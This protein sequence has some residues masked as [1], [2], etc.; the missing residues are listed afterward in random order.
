MR[1]PRQ[2]CIMQTSCLKAKSHEFASLKATVVKLNN[3]VNDENDGNNGVFLSCFVFRTALVAMVGTVVV[4]FYF[5][6]G[7][8]Q[9]AFVGQAILH[10]LDV[11]TT[12]Y[13]H[14]LVVSLNGGSLGEPRGCSTLGI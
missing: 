5:H 4:E 1:L 2:L 12:L 7:F 11:Q 3:K 14:A 13:P 6:V 9:F 8:F 10:V